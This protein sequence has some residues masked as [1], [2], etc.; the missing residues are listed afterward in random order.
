MKY[1]NH[2]EAEEM[3]KVERTPLRLCSVDIMYSVL[4]CAVLPSSG[5]SEK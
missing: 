5:C 1:N 4:S 2:R 3:E